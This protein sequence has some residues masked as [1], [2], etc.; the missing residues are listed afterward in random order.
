MTL[1]PK[2]PNNNY[3]SRFADWVHGCLDCGSVSHLFR[4]CPEKDS[5]KMKFN[6]FQNLWDHVPSTRLRDEY[7]TS[8]SNHLSAQSLTL[9][10]FT[11]NIPSNKSP[12]KRARFVLFLLEFIMF[13]RQLRNQCL[14]L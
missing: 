8:Q 11:S 2:N 5:K 6:C 1:Y 13:L 4:E 9:P 10:S 3:V 14:F 12:I 7:H